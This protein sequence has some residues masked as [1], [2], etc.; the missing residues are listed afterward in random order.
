MAPLVTLTTDFG[1]R[2]AYAAALEAAVLRTAPDVRV[3][4][5]SHM[6]PAGDVAA[7]AYLLEYAT[8][9]FPA[10][11]V[12]LGVV[13]PGVGSGRRILA[14]DAGDFVVVG[15]DNG[16]L[17]RALRGRQVD[18]V[19]LPV[20]SDVSA[21]FQSRDVM[22]PA[23]ALL[24]AGD[25]LPAMGAH[26]DLEVQPPA[27]P[28]PDHGAVDALV[29]H[30]DG[31]GTIVVDLMCTPGRGEGGLRLA[32]RDV[33]L[34]ATFSDVA[35][36]EMVGYRGSIGYLEIAIR[37]GEASQALGLRTGSKVAVEVLA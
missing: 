25:S 23:A 12:H 19:V 31:F 17:D 5:V 22:A 15:P 34:R 2:D 3:V 4:H 33:P 21:T 9:S 28:L 6:V 7:G 30:V 16:L 14:V 32:G 13:D 35:P 36:G 29:V 20:P 18:A 10:G 26:A 11:T 37:D 1:L 24:A 27:P 8:R